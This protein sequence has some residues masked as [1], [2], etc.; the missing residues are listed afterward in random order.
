MAT[1]LLDDGTVESDL[2]E[3]VSQLAS[4]G[5][6]LKRYDPGTSLFSFDLLE[7]DSLT[8]SEKRY[9]IELHNSVFEFIQQENGYLWCD[10]LNLHPGSP[11]LQTLIA[12]YGSYHTHTA[13]EALYVL[14]GEI[15]FGFVK[16]DGSQVQ[17]LVQSQDYIYISAGVEHWCSPGASLN[18]KAVRYFTTADGWV[19]N[20]TGT[21][22]IDSLYKPR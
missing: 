22:L 13:P 1:L 16:P 6:Y 21:Q 15:I 19:P 20:Y 4:L 17:L 8:D 7:Q 18:F 10:L 5:I 14:S 9:I 2:S 3:I 11:T 12:T